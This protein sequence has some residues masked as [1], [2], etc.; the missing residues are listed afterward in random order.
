MLVEFDSMLLEIVLYV[1]GCGSEIHVY[2]NVTE[3]VIS[4]PAFSGCPA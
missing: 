4:G 3:C 1:T 2:Y